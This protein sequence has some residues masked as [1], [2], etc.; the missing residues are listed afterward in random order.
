MR[1]GA[2]WYVPRKDGCLGENSGA[3]I[4]EWVCIGISVDKGEDIINVGR[5]VRLIM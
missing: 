4:D 5:R 2:P 1:G 3:H